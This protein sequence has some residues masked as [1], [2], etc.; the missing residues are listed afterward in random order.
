MSETI[1]KEFRNTK[2]DDTKVI[3][4]WLIIKNSNDYTGTGTYQNDVENEL[5]KL[6]PNV[7]FFEC[8]IDNQNCVKAYFDSNS[9][10]KFNMLSEKLVYKLTIKKYHK[11][12]IRYDKN[13]KA[14][15]ALSS[16]GG[17]HVTSERDFSSLGLNAYV[18]Y[19]PDKNE[20][21]KNGLGE[22]K[23][24][25]HDRCFSLIHEL[26][27]AYHVVYNNY[28]EKYGDS[29]KEETKTCIET[30]KIIEEMRTLKLTNTQNRTAYNFYEG[31]ALLEDLNAKY[32]LNNE[33]EQEI[34]EWGKY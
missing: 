28:D 31:P 2:N 32:M 10:N 25:E 1:R 16:S 7:Q 33:I 23:D 11:T 27:H 24:W 8:K 29:K 17:N 9:K 13:S 6:A 15:F 30:N 34:L 5:K 18:N 12:I 14:N 19:A 4:S 20:P 21:L 22:G 26:I 3:I